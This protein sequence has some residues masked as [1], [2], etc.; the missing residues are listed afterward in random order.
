MRRQR[1]FTLIEMIVVIAVVGVIVAL[2]VP[3]FNDYILVQRLK[4]INAQLVTDFNLARSEAVARNTIGRV[5]F[6]DTDASNTCYTVFTNPVGAF[7][8]Q[9]CDCKLG[10]GLAC[11][12]SNANAAFRSNEVRTVV[13]PRSGGITVMAVGNTLV[14]TNPTPAM[15]FNN[16]TGG[17]VSIPT[18]FVPD[19]MDS[20]SVETAI[21]ST[22]LLRTVVGRA[23]R[24][25]VCSVGSA[26]LGASACP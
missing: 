20:F 21:N 6:D 3:S 24:P 10:P 15:G 1:A 7:L 5:V 25:T 13:V 22:R 8:T 4:S 23:G 12:T 17:L 11:S 2:T 16:I 14:G 18:D 9:R 26:N 19:L